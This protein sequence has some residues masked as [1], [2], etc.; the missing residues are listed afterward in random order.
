[1]KFIF[2]SYGKNPAFNRPEEWIHRIRGYTGIL[3]IL[4]REHHVISIEQINYEGIFFNNGVDYHFL[5]FGKWEL[6]FPAK[7]H[8]YVKA[9]KPDIVFVHG[10]HYPLQILQL[11]IALN[12]KTK[13]IVQNHAEKPGNGYTR[14]LQKLADA[15]IDAYLFTALQMS[16]AW[17]KQGIIKDRKKIYEVMEASSVFGP[18][19]K[20]EAKKFTGA[21][22]D[23]VV[24]WVGRLDQNKDPVTVIK[25]FLKFANEHRTARL[26]MIY[27]TDELLAQIKKLLADAGNKKDSVVLTGKVPHEKMSYWYN[28]ADF[29]ISGSHYEG[30]GVAVCEAMSCGCIP[31]VT[32]ILSFQKITNDGECGLL[33]EPGNEEELLSALFQSMKINLQQEREKV[34]RQ[35]HSALSF[36]AIA[37]T[38]QEIAVS[39]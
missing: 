7:L 14:L 17:I 22:G 29:I 31:I 16:E 24:L 38:I 26:Y 33:Y 20:S 35:F 2:L 37:A 13:I 30:S 23:P 15:S 18:M 28:S 25:G 36:E 34:F 4:S 27:H 12:K 11:R 1:M 10:M 9:L 39:L 21:T 6:K 5:N 19:E 3:E 8:Q 32:K